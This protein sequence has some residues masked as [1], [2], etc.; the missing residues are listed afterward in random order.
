[1]DRA[2]RY[3]VLL[4]H[5]ESQ[6][7]LPKG[8]ARRHRRLSLSPANT[9]PPTNSRVLV[10]GLSKNTQ[11]NYC[12]GNVTAFERKECRCVVRI[13]SDK[14]LSLRLGNLLLGGERAC[15]RPTGNRPVATLLMCGVGVGVGMLL[16]GVL[17]RWLKG[18]SRLQLHDR[19]ML[20]TTVDIMTLYS[21]PRSF[22]PFD[23][24]L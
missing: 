5:D 3:T 21:Y 14:Q 23:S 22:D 18:G 16:V 7:L 20:S 11:Y 10:H 17:R 13:G 12:W 19:A 6:Q 15:R 24:D 4:T 2:C 1:M 8:D 9:I